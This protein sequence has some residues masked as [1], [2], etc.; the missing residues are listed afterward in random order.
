[1]VYDRSGCGEPLVLMHGIGCSRRVW[2]AVTPQLVSECDVLAVDLPGFGESPPMAAGTAPSAFAL[3]GAVAE[4]LDELGMPTA[5]LAGNSLGGWVCLE[6]A[7]RGRA[8]SVVLL[9]PAGL[10]RKTTPLEA[11]V[12][13]AGSHRLA[14]WLSRYGLPLLRSRLLRTAILSHAV[15][16]PW[17]MSRQDACAL[18]CDLAQSPGFDDTWRAIRNDRFTGGRSLAIPV[19]LAFGSRDRVLLRHRARFADE[20]PPHTVH[21]R[22]RGCGHLPTFD[23]PQAIVATLLDSVLRPRLAGSRRWS[24]C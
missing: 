14:P 11:V 23:D 8:R 24:T 19:T 22:L 3:A 18:V 20:L 15:G 7:K 21:R 10:W 16:R 1:M 17:R 4:L 5:H 13:V 12:A 9:S 2:D 6:L